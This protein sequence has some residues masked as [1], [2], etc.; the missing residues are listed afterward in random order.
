MRRRFSYLATFAT[1]LLSNNMDSLEIQKFDR[2]KD[3]NKMRGYARRG[4]EFKAQP[5]KR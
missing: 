2:W 5:S 4:R 1:I 3:Y